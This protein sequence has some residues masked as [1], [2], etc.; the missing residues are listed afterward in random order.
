MKEDEIG[1]EMELSEESFVSTKNYGNLREAW[2][3]KY[4]HLFTTSYI[5]RTLAAFMLMHI[6]VTAIV[7]A[8]SPMTSVPGQE[9]P[10][11]WEF[12]PFI[13]FL[14]VYMF[15]GVPVLLYWFWRIEDVY[16]IR[17]ELISVAI[18]AMV[19]FLL[20]LI[21]LFLPSL[22]TLEKSFAAYVWGVIVLIL[23]HTL[24]VVYPIYELRKSR[25]V[26]ANSN[27][28]H[29]FDQ[30]LTD[31]T[32]FE[33]FKAYTIKDFSVENPLFYERCR[34]LRDTQSRL[35]IP[36]KESINA[37]TRNELLSMYETFINPKSEFQVNLSSATILELTRQ[38]ESG[39]LSLNMFSRAER[40]IHL[41]MYQNT[42]PRY[43]RYTNMKI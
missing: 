20:Y 32:L 33:D 41:L 18:I 25:L 2:Y 35:R 15:L 27:N 34:K 31:P 36:G 43:I 26:R 16:G 24:F 13:G 9:C 30:I 22:R 3:Y 5:L 38:F 28:T 10:L 21:F 7:N 29:V 12:Y 37:K 14:V 6:G 23:T 1:Y 19:G 40:E 42:F 17:K 4:R 11:S 39:E 8:I